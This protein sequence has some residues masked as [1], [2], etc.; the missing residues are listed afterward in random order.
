MRLLG[1]FDFRNKRILV[2]CDFNV[3]LSKE[4]EILDDFRIKQAL[5]TIFYLMENKAKIVLMSHLGRPE[6]KA[7]EGLKMDPVQ[8]RLME[9]LDV[10]VTK[11]PDCIGEEIEKWTK[12]MIPGEILILENLRFHKGEEDGDK[13]FAAELAKMGDIYIN[14]AFGASHRAHASISGV[15]EFLPS[16][17]GLLLQKEVEELSALMKNPQKP[18]VAVIGGA[19]ADTKMKVVNRISAVADQVLISGLLDKAIAKENINLDYPEKVVKPVDEARDGKDIGPETI[20]IFKEKILGAKTVFWNGPF[21]KIEEE[22]FFRGTEEIAKAIIKSGAHSVIGGGETVEFVNRIGL[23]QKFS[24]V[25]TGGGAMLEFLSGKELPG[26]K[27][28]K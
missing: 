24:H 16:G 12:K 3:P 26:I 17:A 22:E 27:A 9:Y 18:L 23:L 19:K 13:A 15:P 11:A 6:G 10:S 14:N 2:R 8:I 1:D 20:R 25:S 7:V 4:G 28:L 5:P 21:G